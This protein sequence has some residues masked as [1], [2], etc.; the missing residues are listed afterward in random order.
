MET[1]VENTYDSQ[2]PAEPARPQFL[3][4]LC[5]LTWVCCGLLFIMTIWGVVGKPSPE[6]QYEQLEKM[7]EVSPEMADKMEAAWEAQENSNQTVSLAVNL[8]GLALSAFGAFMMWQLKKQGFYVYIAGEAIPYLGFL[9]GGG[10]AM[11][12]SMGGPAMAAIVVGLMVLF[13]LAFIIMYGVNL[14]HMRR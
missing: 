3:T 8:V 9:T 11:T 1:T 12:L 7:R 2:T 6:E 10:E 5:I 4:V 13:D 14:K